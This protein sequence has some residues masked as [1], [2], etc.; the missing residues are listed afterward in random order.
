[1]EPPDPSRGC[2]TFTLP[3]VLDFLRGINFV[4]QAWTDVPGAH[5]VVR[6]IYIELVSGKVLIHTS[7]YTRD[8]SQGST[9]RH[10]S[11]S[12]GLSWSR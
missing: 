3:A 5:H 11:S 10:S 12:S 9:R 4:F 1:M 6:V 2:R 8:N 7:R